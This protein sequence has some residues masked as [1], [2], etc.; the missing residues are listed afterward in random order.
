MEAGGLRVLAIEGNEPDA[1]AFKPCARETRLERLQSSGAAYITDFSFFKKVF[2]ERSG[3]TVSTIHEV[4][5][6][7]FDV[8]I[9]FGLLQDM[10]LG[11]QESRNT[12][13]PTSVMSTVI[14]RRASCYTS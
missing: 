5:G 2:R 13:C 12:Q 11:V 1:K 7:E 8:V 3:I 14:S 6:A 10:E 4:K 9:G